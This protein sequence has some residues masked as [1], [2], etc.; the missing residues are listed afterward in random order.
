MIP[1]EQL[2]LLDAAS[3]AAE[4][5]GCKIEVIDLSSLGFMERRRVKGVIPRIEI[6]KQTITG[7]PMS[8]EIVEFT[9]GL[10]LEI[11]QVSS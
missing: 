5:L 3:R 9:R 4:K 1:Q 7:L 6:G 11:E 8:D 10:I 2:I